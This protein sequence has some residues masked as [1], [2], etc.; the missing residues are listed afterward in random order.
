MAIAVWFG[1]EGVTRE[2]YEQVIRG[3]RDKGMEFPQARRY[4]VAFPTPDGW[5]VVDVWDSREAFQA[6]GETLVPLT[7]EAG[8]GPI[9]PQIVDVHAEIAGVERRI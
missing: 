7:Q 5:G 6:F 3:L 9:D 2:Q 1:L 8:M 4:H